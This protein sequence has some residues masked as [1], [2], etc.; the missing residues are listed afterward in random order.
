MLTA[1]ESRGEV[2]S[3]SAPTTPSVD[4]VELSIGLAQAGTLAGELVLS[5]AMV[6]IGGSRPNT[7]AEIVH[8]ATCL[9]KAGRAGSPPSGIDE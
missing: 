7:L 4:V 8:R 3:G 9:R 1:C 5:V 6:V 2:R